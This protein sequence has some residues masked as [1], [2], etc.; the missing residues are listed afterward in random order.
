MIQIQLEKAPPVA[1]G[2]IEHLLACHR[3]IEQRLDVLERAGAAL[4]ENPEPSLIAIANSLRFMDVSGVLHTVDEEESVFPRIRDTAST[5]EIAY[6]DKLE[7]EHREA[8]EVY[9]RLKEVSTALMGAVTADL[10]H[11]YRQLVNKLG[12]AYRSHIASEDTVLVEL[13]RRVLKQDELEIIQAEMRAR[14]R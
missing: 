1:E 7:A 13:G 11:E 6:L 8:D 5:E 12:S 9:V 2:P 3:R 4:E 14:R 10:I